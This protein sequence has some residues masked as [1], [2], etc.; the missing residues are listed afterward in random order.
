MALYETP[1]LRTFPVNLN[2]KQK[3]NAAVNHVKKHPVPYAVGLALVVQATV[4]FAIDTKKGLVYMD[5]LIEDMQRTGKGSYFRDLNTGETV[6]TVL[7]DPEK[8]PELKFLD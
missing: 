1:R 5:D 2:V 7:Y 8:H 3:L 4:R 6:L